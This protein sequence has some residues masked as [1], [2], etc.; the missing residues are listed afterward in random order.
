MTRMIAPA[1][2]RRDRQPSLSGVGPGPGG[3]RRSW[4]R[5]MP[6]I[7]GIVVISTVVLFVRAEFASLV[8]PVLLDGW[9]AYMGACVV[10]QVGTLA[11]SMV[12]RWRAARPRLFWVRLGQITSIAF[13]A[14]IVASVWILMPPADDILRLLMIILCMWFIAMVIILNADRLSIVGALA[15]VASMAAFTLVYDIQYAIPLA[16]FLIMEGIA[17][18]MIRRLIWRAAE[19][20]D[21]A[22]QIVRKERDAKTRFIA[23]ASHDLQQPLQAASLYFDQILDSTDAGQR[24]RAIAGARSAF[25]S[26]QRLLE[27]M[28]DHLR[29]EAGAAPVR[30]EPVALDDLLAAI[31]L[32]HGAAARAAG[33]RIRMVSTSLSVLGDRAMLTRTIGNLVTNAIRHGQGERILIGA[34][35]A[36]GRAEIWVIDDGNGIPAADVATIFDDYAQGAQHRGAERGGFGLGLA[37]ARRMAHLMSGTIDLDRRWTSGAAFVLRL[38]LADPA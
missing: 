19:T 12:P 23:S 36:R 6:L 2:W 15:V 27:T 32:E 38:R 37:S 9:L 1:A 14:G 35:R 31:A 30:I 29:L 13:C 4:A 16:G 24:E 33:M 28:L 21:A 25:A 11:A 20:R 5:A 34:R 8:D 18:V 7:V 26:T 22:L 10:F 3:A 17:L